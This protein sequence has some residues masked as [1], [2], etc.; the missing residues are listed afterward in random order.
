MLFCEHRGAWL[1]PVSYSTVLILPAQQSSCRS[2]AVTPLKEK[3]EENV[4]VSFCLSFSLFH[5]NFSRIIFGTIFS[6]L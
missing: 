5:W 2:S 1:L 3:N 4:F 6:L